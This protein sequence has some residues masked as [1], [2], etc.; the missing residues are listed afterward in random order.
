[1]ALK[2][3]LRPQASIKVRAAIKLPTDLADV[4]ANTNLA[5]L[6][7]A[8]AAASAAAAAASETAAETAETNAETAETNAEAAQAAAEAA[9]AAAEAAQAAAEAAKTAAETA[10]TNA[11]TA[12]TNAEAAQVAAEAALDEFDDIYLGSHASDPTLDNDGNALV[13]GQ[14]YWNS[15]SNALKV[16][17][18][19]AW[20]PAGGGLDPANNLSDVADADTSADN[21]NAVRFTSQTLSDSEKDQARANIGV[22]GKNRLINGAFSVSQQNIA[23]A[24]STSDNSYWADGWRYIGEASAT[25]TA[26]DTTLGGSYPFDG[27][28][29]FTGT[30]DKGGA[31]QVIEGLNCKDLRGKSIAASA[32]LAVNNA[33]L[34]NIKMGIAEFTGTEDAVSGDPVSTWGADGV[35]PTLAASWAFINTPANLS[36][37]TSGALY[38]VTATVGASA[39]NLAVIIWNDDKSYNANDY[40]LLTNVQLEEGT[41]AT[42]FELRPFGLELMLCLRYYQ[43]SFALETAPAQ[44][45][46][47][48]TGDYVF[49]APVAG[50]GNQ[51]SPSFTFS[52]PMRTTPTVTTYNPSAANALLRDINAAAD[53]GAIT[54]T[55]SQKMLRVAG[56]GNASTSAGNSMTFHWTADARL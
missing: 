47:T 49:P 37:T 55:T 48:G 43:K 4:L 20:Q 12:E 28:I 24:T 13:E 2:I 34:G 17:D 6:A 26:R 27:K 16:Y 18:G 53:G 8:A 41:V 30:T 1:M 32:V 46:G 25:C 50:T 38:S 19:A 45:V 35:T 22:I 31:F 54:V 51:R 29:L 5:E 42:P 15:A 33:R 3:R 21:L 11:E 44:N 56:A 36:V 40:I 10:E 39:N 9:Q 52:V 7:A 23:V 14:L